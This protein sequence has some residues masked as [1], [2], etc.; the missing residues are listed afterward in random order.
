MESLKVGNR[1]DVLSERIKRLKEEAL[2]SPLSIDLARIRAYTK[3]WKDMGEEGE[4]NPCLRAALALRE[5]M[6]TIDVAIGE[7]DLLVGTKGKSLMTD[8]IPIE[9]YNF[10]GAANVISLLPLYIAMNP[11]TQRE[12]I[13]A[14]EECRKEL[15]GEILPF[16]RKRTAQERKMEAWRKEGLYRPLVLPLKN[17][18]DIAR[19]YR[20]FGGGKKL[21][22]IASVARGGTEGAAQRQEK[23]ELLSPGALREWLRRLASGCSVTRAALGM[24]TPRGAMGL[25]R[26]I[27]A[28]VNEWFPDLLWF[29]G[30][31][32]GHLIP[33]FHRVLEIGFEGIAAKARDGLARLHGEEPDHQHRRDFLGSAIVAAEAVREFAGRYAD[34]AE[35]IAGAEKDATRREE[36]LAIAERCRRVP[37]KPPRDF[38]EALQS[39]YFTHVALIISYGF[40]NVFSA[41]R[42]DQY[43]Y[44]YYRKDLEE[45]RLSRGQA[46]E[47]LEE[48]LIK[49]SR[50]RFFGPNNVTIGGLDREGRDATNELSYLYLEAFENLGGMGN[51]LSVRISHQTPRDFLL[52]TCAVNRRT[53]GVSLLNDEV[54]VRDLVEDGYALED[55]RNYSIVGC[56]E[57]HGTGDSYSPTALNGFWLAGVAEMALNRGRRKV[58]GSRCIGLAT[59]DPRT[60]RSFDEVKEAFA[61]QLSFVIDRAVRMKEVSDRVFAD[62]FPN[63][64]LSSTIEG[65][66]ESG[67]DAT[68]GGARYNHGCVNIQGLGT[69]AD[70]LA[71]I[72]WAVFEERIV[73]MD[74]LLRALDND[75]R[76]R[77]S[78]RQ[79]LLRKAPKYGNDDPRADEIAEWISRVFTEEAGK[80]RSFRGDPYRCSCVSSATQLVEGYFCPATP[81]G[82]RALEPVSNSMSPTNGVERSG[83][84]A[85]L[86]SA[87]LAGNADYSDGTALNVRINPLALR[88]G[89]N[90]EKLA[91]L[92]EGYFALGGRHVQL[93]PMDAGTLRDAQAHPEKYPDL[94]V[95]VS[96][97]SAR[98]VELPRALQD[99]IIARTEFQRL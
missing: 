29:S 76:G 40:D 59:P 34:L 27:L 54:I 51:G 72:K 20:A 65:C 25:P 14:L 5:T 44:P 32:Q 19:A 39:L 46:L 3:I 90:V 16:W 18:M 71:A 2:A 63:P 88:A 30:A 36:L 23:R 82:R 10:E 93:N 80:Y 60:F 48:Y 35:S 66:L 91:S 64:L 83:L 96:G 61:A 4:R 73:T 84:T 55:A 97:Y 7:S 21:M 78:L 68:R 52:R 92:V 17:P 87:A 56:V 37:W 77:E 28:F 74:E 38:M 70:S 31:M 22:G 58:T 94:T 75:F 81:D 26:R 43:L 47:A 99:D 85:V 1:T 86:R 67:M 6:R 45:G 41:G 11:P 13:H 33:G 95:K 69:A 98:F 79:N 12:F 62:S 49:I 24:S 9:R 50:N 8:I 42:V 57:P 89:E 15:D 53:A